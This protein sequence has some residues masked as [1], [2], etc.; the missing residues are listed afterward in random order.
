MNSRQK[1]LLRILLLHENGA[2]QIKDLSERLDCAEKTVRN[3]LDRLEETLDHYP[4][5]VLSRKPGIGINIQIDEEDREAIFQTLLS[6]ETK[7]TEERLIEIA[8]HL[9]TSYKPITLQDFADRYYVQKIAIKKDMDL[10]SGWLERFELQLISK[11]RLGNV[12]QG[13]E[14]KKR[15]ALAHL[16]DLTRTIP[17]E[18]NYV[19]DLFLPYEIA[20]VRKALVE[21]QR[22]YTISFTDDALE[23]LL[24]HA[25]IM[26]K[27]TRQKSPVFVHAAEQAKASERKEYTYA[28]WFF[29]QMTKAFQMNFPSEERAY[30]TWH[31]ISAKKTE[32]SVEQ[33]LKYEV[34]ETDIVKLL[35][36]KLEKLTLF[37]FQTDTILIKG[38]AIHMHS[39]I[40]R[41]QYGFPIRNPLL[42]NIKKMYPYMF[43]MA[44]LTLEEIN[45][46]FHI[47][48]PEDE[49]A[50]IVLHFQASIERLESKSS[51]KK[52]ALIVCHM[53]IGMS[54]LLEAKI[55]QQYQ[56]IDV[57]G[58]IGKAEIPDYVKQHE[59]DFIISTVP[60][61]K[62]KQEHIVV[63]P[64][65][66]QHD[67]KQLNYF[68]EELQQKKSESYNLDHLTTFLHEEFLFFEVEK[69]HRYQV[70][71]MLA[72]ALYQK[73]YVDKE[74]IHS[75]VSRERSSATAI[76]GR[77]AIP[78]GNP[79]MIQKSM[80]AVAMMKEPIEWGNELVSIVLMLAISKENHQNMRAII[81]QIASLSESP[82][83][84]QDLLAKKNFQDFM[85]VLTKKG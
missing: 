51:A 53:G 83:I 16:S 30:F 2:L 31:L 13:S 80:I 6:S 22:E 25:L 45:S 9:L 10:I 70:V 18:R 11:P 20:A 60:L 68:L 56:E 4:S 23:S 3:D 12:I 37:P 64:L 58:C 1:E 39:V 82:F 54:H 48:I 66:S 84:V 59:V 76:G 32:E 17:A 38:L 24:V 79:A 43:N 46:T 28:G 44:I 19:L 50:Y 47:D 52:K 77:V 67:K 62:V 63:S 55:E 7:T 36:S 71:E 57:V 61:E 41:I 29:D 75:A 42:P 14:L 73:G 35:V 15:N 65:F 34:A 49:A 5:A 69:E 27:R 85:Q 33:E 78:H 26:I 81:G 8:F 21:M 74:F 72:M 40:H